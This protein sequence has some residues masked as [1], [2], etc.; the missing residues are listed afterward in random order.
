[1][2]NRF[3]QLLMRQILF[4]LLLI[5][6]SGLLLHELSFFL[7]SFLGAITLNILLQKP[8]KLL[9]EKWH[10]AGSWAA[11]FLLAVLVIL[12]SGVIGLLFHQVFSRVTS[13]N[14][15]MITEGIDIIRI[16]VEGWLG[17][18]IIPDDLVEQIGKMMGKVASSLFNTTY[19]VFANFT[20]TLFL[21]Y[22]MLISDSSYKDIIV[23]FLPLSPN[24]KQLLQ[25]EVF[26]MIYGN[27]IG[28]PLMMLLQ[29]LFA[30]I[31]YLLFGLSDA[32]F[33]GLFTGFFSI[34]PIIGTA[35]IWIPLAT[36]LIASGAIFNGIG[37]LLF[38]SLVITNVDNLFRFL[39]MK[40]IANVHPL[41]TV[42]GVIIG[43]PMFGFWG[44][45]FGPS[46]LSVFLLLVKTYRNEY[47]LPAE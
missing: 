31:G 40:R 1:M 25:K 4:L 47:L 27:T 35:V 29:G 43:V 20:M 6:L 13:I 7:S 46:L 36:Y 28:I 41:I 10:W 22:F 21:L 45:I 37:L 5:L 12:L 23:D 30:Y 38:G 9:K 15:T 32:L 16:K 42:F 33:W 2:D 24:N 11:I 39:L 18:N 8:M 26:Q 44:I 3:D 19:S 34:I 17:Y 14:L